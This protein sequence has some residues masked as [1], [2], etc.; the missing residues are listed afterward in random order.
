MLV[1]ESVEFPVFGN[2]QALSLE[3]CFL[4]KCNLS[5]KLEALGSFVQNAPCLKKLTLYSCMVIN[6]F[7]I[8]LHLSHD[9][10][11]F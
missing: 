9:L 3:N 8:Y 1:E 11:S 5:D 6:P 7:S 10:F 4:D 2:L